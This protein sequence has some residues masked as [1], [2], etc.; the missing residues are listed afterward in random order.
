MEQTTFEIWKKNAFQIIK[1]T[2]IVMAFVAI[3]YSS[4]VAILNGKALSTTNQ[5]LVLE[6]KKTEKLKTELREVSDALEKERNKS[7]KTRVAASSTEL[8]C[9][10]PGTIARKFNNPCNVKSPSN[11]GRWKGQIGEDRYRH[12][13]FR[14]IFHGIRAAAITLRSYYQR[15]GIKTIAGIIDRFCGGNPGYV[16]F[17][18]AEMSLKPDQEFDVLDRIPELV[19]LMSQ[20]ESSRRL[21]EDFVVTLDVIR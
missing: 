8:V 1:I 10:G 4:T 2:S 12:A 16:K 13:H 18:C 11:G 21:P 6:M 17:L 20:Y 3:I 14:S 5:R 7:G 9:G 19:W 15:H